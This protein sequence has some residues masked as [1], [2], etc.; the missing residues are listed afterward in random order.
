MEYSLFK[1]LL[2]IS[3]KKIGINMAESYLTNSLI[4]QNNSGNSS[5]EF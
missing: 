3:V 1:I 5:K 4:I 2:L